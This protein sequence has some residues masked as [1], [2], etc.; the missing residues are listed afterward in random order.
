MQGDECP[1]TSYFQVHHR[2]K[3]FDPYPNETTTMTIYIYIWQWN[4][5]NTQSHSSN[6]QKTNRKK[7]AQLPSSQHVA[8]YFGKT[9]L[10]YPQ[11]HKRLQLGRPKAIASEHGDNCLALEDKFPMGSY[12]CVLKF[13]F[14]WMMF[15][16]LQYFFVPCKTVQGQNPRMT[17]GVLQ[18]AC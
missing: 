10:R 14:C 8:K 6:T 13:L 9:V 4:M 3:I 17:S 7:N 12:I 16:D 1:F 18:T 5:E 2:T 15:Q 11:L